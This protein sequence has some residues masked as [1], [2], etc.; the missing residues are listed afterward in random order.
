M[1]IPD[2]GHLKSVIINWHNFCQTMPDLKNKHYTSAKL[3]FWILIMGTA[4]CSKLG[5]S[6]PVHTNLVLFSF[7]APLSFGILQKSIILKAS[8]EIHVYVSRSFSNSQYEMPVCHTP[9]RSLG[10]VLISL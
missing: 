1:N 7:R 10:G 5:L 8:A 9:Y 6:S 4:T 2:T 3:L